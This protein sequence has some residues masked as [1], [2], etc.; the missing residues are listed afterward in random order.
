MP[1]KV[2][3]KGCEKVLNAPD[4]LRGKTV[5]CPK[6]QSPLKI[7][8]G[9]KKRPAPAAAAAEPERRPRRQ[10][11]HE[12]DLFGDL[13]LRRAEDRNVK[14]CPRCATEVD[15]DDIECLNCG[16]NIS[17]GVL[18]EKQR[19]ARARKGPDPDEYWGKIWSDGWKFTK[20][21]WKLALQTAGMYIL[22]GA[23]S[24]CALRTA[25]WCYEGYIQTIL[26]EAAA[27]NG[28]ITARSRF[29]PF[30]VDATKASP[31]TLLNKRYTRETAFTPP[32]VMAAMPLNNPPFIFWC[33]MYGVFSLALG[34][35]FWFVGT[36][37]I[38]ATMV[39]K[40]KVKELKGDFFAYISL[41]IK[42]VTWP[43]ILWGPVFFAMMFITAI[44][45]IAGIGLGLLLLLITLPMY[46]VC[47][48]HMFQN[49]VYKAYLAVPMLRITFKNFGP[50]AYWAVS[51]VIV[52]LILFITAGVL[53]ALSVRVGSEYAG[54]LANAKKWIA[55][56]VVSFEGPWSQFTFYELP[57]LFLLCVLL[58][59][60]VAAATGF[61]TMFMMRGIGLFGRYFGDR[62]ELMNECDAG[63]PCGF[64]P[65][66]LAAIV[67][68]WM[69]PLTSILVASNRLLQ[70]INLFMNLIV[71]V[72]FLT[73]P[74][75][76]KLFAFPII[77][78][79]VIVLQI[80]TYYAIQESGYEQA[81]TGKNAQNIIVVDM[82]GNRITTK[83]ATIRLA[84]KILS[85]LPLFG[86]FFMAAFNDKKQA[87]HDTMAN[88]QVVWRGESEQSRL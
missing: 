68:F 63:V 6:C 34:G 25:N 30:K 76:L 21:H 71:V 32:V 46:A 7:P 84:A 86:G 31:V 4:K 61:A 81:T 50:A 52:N 16:V 8:T 35:W 55:S 24:I 80:W 48:V 53:A 82:E 36:N 67:D 11:E 33:F 85:T 65:R 41:G 15:P 69:L 74:P 87:L 49:Y 57:T 39:G 23:L 45:P 27:S 88:T 78:L 26:D 66:Y 60:P 64:G 72:V 28:K 79:F 42:A 18:S 1:V 77:L 40:R 19:K 70:I 29:E 83:A 2:R 54:V 37:I 13:D 73:F 44:V 5:K 10:A 14:L 43:V 22:L 38:S 75:E 20:A 56:N 58:L 59:L 3:C 17:T 9:K 12:D 47:M 51:A 62:L